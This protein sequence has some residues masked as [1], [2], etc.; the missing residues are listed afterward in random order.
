MSSPNAWLDR[1]RPFHVTGH[2]LATV[3]VTGQAQRAAWAAKTVPPVEVI[4]DGLWCVPVPI[5]ANPLRYTSIYVLADDASLTLIDSGTDTEDGWEALCAG[6]ATIGASV[7]DV[8][9]CLLTH[10]HFDH[11]GLAARIRAA[12]GAW[13]GM[14]PADVDTM[15]R[16]GFGDPQLALDRETHWLT[17]LGATCDEVTRILTEHWFG[18][19]SQGVAF[20]PDRLVLDGDLLTASGRTL[21]AIHTPG[22]TPGHLCFHDERSQC[23]FAGDHVLPR[24]TPNVSADRRTGSDSLGDFLNS[25]DKVDGMPIGEVLPAHEWRFRGLDVR[26]AEIRRHHEHRLAELAAVLH[27]HPDAVPWDLAAE[28][29]WSRPW[30]QYSG[31]MQITA[32]SE[33]AAHLMHLVR[34]GLAS[35]SDGAPPRYSA[36]EGQLATHP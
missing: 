3:E 22:H 9:G 27:D 26:T 13:I 5:P 20:E 32:V 14:H 11:S 17:H 30:S 18:P 31:T 36:I 7:D 15:Q 21:R 12:S 8:A 33:T 28:L 19:G 35:V 10:F 4:H 24:I 34:R 1:I 16:L 25:L 23:L 29:T 6:L 2:R